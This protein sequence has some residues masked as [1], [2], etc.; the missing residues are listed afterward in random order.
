MNASR[1]VQRDLPR[2]YRGRD[3][4]WWLKVRFAS[5]TRPKTYTTT[6]ETTP[7]SYPGCAVG[8]EL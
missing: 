8:I 2:R 1:G 4:I 3:L 5:G 6:W 7:I